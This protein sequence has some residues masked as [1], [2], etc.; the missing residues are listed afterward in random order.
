MCWRAGFRLS[1]RA[2]NRDEAAAALLAEAA[3]IDEVLSEPCLAADLH[4]KPGR[5]T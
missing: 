4:E 5:T 2:E 3:Q 1:F